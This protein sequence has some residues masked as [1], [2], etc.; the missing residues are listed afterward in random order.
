LR[1]LIIED[2]AKLAEQVRSGLEREGFSVDTA[3][4]GDDGEDKAFINEY[5]TILLDLNLPDA[6][7]LDI[8][9]NLRETGIHTPV[10][11]VT[12]RDDVEQR[13]HGLDLGADDYL[14][15]PFEF[16]E[17]RARVQA[18]I[19]RFQGRTNPLINIG[20]ITVNPQ[21]HS[22]DYDGKV[23]TLKPKEFD[24][25]EYIAG[26]YPAVVPAEEII[27]HVYDEDFDPFSS[28]VRVHIARLKKTLS[29]AAGGE[30]LKTIRGKGYVLCEKPE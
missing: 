23:L 7:G 28:V 25:L 19:R 11:I 10:I 13:A 5:D 24:I 26:R 2:N 29:A 12:A 3:L 14:V 8:L 22:A 27:E 30:I 18:V 16:V 4:T 15:K 21:S 1:I 17:L 9:K 20:L 6:D